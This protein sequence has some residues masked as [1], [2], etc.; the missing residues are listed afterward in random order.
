M[1]T[2]KRE[3]EREKEIEHACTY[4]HTR[5][6]TRTHRC[7]ITMQIAP[8]VFAQQLNS[9]WERRKEPLDFHSTH[10]FISLSPFLCDCFPTLFICMLNGLCL[11]P[12]ATLAHKLRAS[13][14]PPLAHC[15]SDPIA[16]AIAFFF[17]VCWFFSANKERERE[18]EREHARALCIQQP[19]FS[20]L[21]L[22]L[23]LIN[24]FVSHCLQ[25]LS[26]FDLLCRREMCIKC[27]SRGFVCVLH[28]SVT[29][30][31]SNAHTHTRIWN[32]THVNTTGT[33]L[34]H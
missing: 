7:P 28:K 33:S 25:N 2:R 18:R 23:I 32:K 30:S 4:A 31:I 10:S 22:C 20:L 19:F 15:R 13:P 27:L 14:A 34:T 8:A 9:L 26:I 1:R 5:T 3:R 29:H 12:R 24:A 17:C 6:Y 21:L 11:I 16:F